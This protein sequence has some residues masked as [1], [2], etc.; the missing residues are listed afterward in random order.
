MLFISSE[1]LFSFLRYLNFCLD[2]FGHVGKRL[3]KKLKVN[4]KIYVVTA[5]LTNYYNTHIGQYIKK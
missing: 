5:W 3:D 2:F 4:L 1:E